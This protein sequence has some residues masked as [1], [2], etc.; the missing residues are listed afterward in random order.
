VLL[1]GTKNPCFH[2]YTLIKLL[3]GA[4]SKLTFSVQF[5]FTMQEDADS[6]FEQCR[7]KK[8]EALLEI[9]K[10]LDAVPAQSPL[11]PKLLQQLLVMVQVS[12]TITT[13][14]P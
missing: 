12:F 5:D 1:A 2:F 7:Q 3:R 14:S 8:R 4:I 11:P 9:Y 13:S 10:Y 6:V